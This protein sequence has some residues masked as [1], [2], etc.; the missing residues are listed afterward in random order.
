MEENDVNRDLMLIG[1]SAGSLGVIIY[2]LQHLEQDR[3]AIIIILHRKESAEPML[4][5]LLSSRTQ[6]QVKEAEEKEIITPGYVYLAPANYHL[7]IEEDSTLSLD[8]SEKI[9]FSRPSIDVTFE[10]AAVAY[11][12]KTIGILLSGGNNDGAEGLKKIRE[13]GGL[14]IVQDP[15][16]ADVAFMPEYAL[17]M[18]KPD[19]VLSKESIIRFLNNL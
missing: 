10:S 4:A 18:S 16:T 19:F 13:A 8:A 12:N 14:T 9:N 11:K 7:L 3:F 17:S 6:F 5:E 2:I 1:G 15:A